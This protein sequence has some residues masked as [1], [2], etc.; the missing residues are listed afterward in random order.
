MNTYQ[1]SKNFS[2]SRYSDSEL[3]VKVNSIIDKMTDNAHFP[4]PSPTLEALT[5][6]ANA[7]ESA[8]EKAKGG[9][10][11]DTEIKNNCRTELTALLKE[12]VYYIQITS[13]GDKVIILSSGFD[14]NKQPSTVGPLPN[15][16]NLKNCNGTKQRKCS[17]KLQGD[18]ESYRL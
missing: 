11:E 2:T 10:I 17:S 18:S 3:E 9:S 6:A 5:N 14:V 15:A 8:L 7:F 1:V 16:S 13:K 12:M 4:T